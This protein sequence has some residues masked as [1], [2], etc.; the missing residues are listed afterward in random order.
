MEDNAAGVGKLHHGG[1]IAVNCLA[2]RLD[3]AVVRPLGGDLHIELHV[4]Q[5]RRGGIAQ[6]LAG[7][8]AVQGELISIGRARGIAQVDR[9]GIDVRTQQLRLEGGG[10]GNLPAAAEGEGLG[11]NLA[12][13]GIVQRQ[14][15]IQGDIAALARQCGRVALEGDTAGLHL[16]E[17]AVEILHRFAGEGAVGEVG[18]LDSLELLLDL[19]DGLE[20]AQGNGRAVHIAH[21]GEVGGRI[22]QERH[23]LVEGHGFAIQVDGFIHVELAVFVQQA[24]LL[25]H[26]RGLG[27]ASAG[28]GVQLVENGLVDGRVVSQQIPH[29]GQCRHGN[30]REHQN[31]RQKQA[32]DAFSH[33]FPPLDCVVCRA[34]CAQ[35][36]K[37]A[38]SFVIPG[39]KS[40]RSMLYLNMDPWL[41]TSPKRGIFPLGYF[42]YFICRPYKKSG[43]VG[44]GAG[45]MPARGAAAIPEG[46]PT[47]LLGYGRP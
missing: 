41:Y 13:A 34:A 35:S 12:A 45:F 46:F 10:K 37:A 38:P 19:H 20:I 14:R 2:G 23:D 36:A 21:L 44:V 18:L 9:Y 11:A 24:V 27:A 16:I 31:N 3:G 17:E 40:Q 33:S 1:L 6:G 29:G 39:K 30:H 47:T 26:G 32:D 42:G 25:Q 43:S 8:G 15:K 28:E 7:G 5:V 4:R 22:L